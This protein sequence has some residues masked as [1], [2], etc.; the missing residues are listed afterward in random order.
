MTDKVNIDKIV[1]K[2]IEAKQPRREFV[3]LMEEFKNRI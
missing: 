3:Q 2:L 1:E